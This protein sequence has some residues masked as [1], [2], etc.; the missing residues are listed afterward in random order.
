VVAAY[1]AKYPAPATTLSLSIEVGA[2]DADIAV[3]ALKTACSN[4]DLS[5]AG[6]A[7]GLRALTAF[8][9]GIIGPDDFSNPAKATDNVTYIL[10]PS[11]TAV[12][13]MMVTQDKTVS[14]LV[15]QFQT[16]KG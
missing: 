6:I 1:Q 7:A 13:G 4:K 3:Q 8:N 11:T 5:R 16:A 10:Q 2:Y 12:G 9:D 14:P 15:G